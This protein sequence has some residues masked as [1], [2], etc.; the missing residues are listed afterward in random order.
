VPRSS[1]RRAGG[2]L[3]QVVAAHD[4]K[5]EATDLHR[6]AQPLATGS[7]DNETTATLFVG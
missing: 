6:W 4:A 3:D 2:A 7:A 1:D 5:P